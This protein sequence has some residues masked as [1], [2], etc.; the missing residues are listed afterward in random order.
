MASFSLKNAHFSILLLHS[1]PNL[2]MFLL[3]YMS[4]ILYA[5]SLDRGIII[6]VKSF[7]RLTQKPQYLCDIGLQTDRRTTDRRQFYY[8]RQQHSFFP[9]L[10]SVT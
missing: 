6:R 7:L 5:E 8:K 10:L 4:Q 3:H 9:T 2:K 1:I